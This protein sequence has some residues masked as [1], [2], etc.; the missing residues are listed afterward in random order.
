EER[1]Q[2]P[3]FV[4]EAR[5][6]QPRRRGETDAF[7]M[8]QQ[9]VHRQ[10]PRPR[11]ADHHVAQAMNLCAAASFQADPITRRDHGPLSGHRRSR[12]HAFSPCPAQIFGCS[13][14]ALRMLSESSKA[15][16]NTDELDE[17][18]AHR[19]IHIGPGYPKRR[20]ASDG[21]GK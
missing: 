3:A 12:A 16:S 9:R 19:P 14:D 1:Q 15:T 2:L 8:A 11:A 17:T 7:E 6:D 18:D 20:T 4:V 13:L 5:A 21:F 10:S